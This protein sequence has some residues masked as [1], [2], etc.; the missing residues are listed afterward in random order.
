MRR[1]LSVLL[2]LAGAACGEPSE[3]MPSGAL[4]LPDA[5]RC[6]PVRE[7]NPELVAL[8][9][10][11]LEQLNEARAQGRGCGPRG[12]FAEAP[13]LRL[14]GALTCAAR[15]HAF[16]MAQREFFDHID[17]DDVTAWDRI[18]AVDY[19]FATAD[20]VIASA[21]LA[22]EDI[23]SDIW[24][25]REGSCAALSASSYVDV[26]IGVALPFTEPVPDNDGLDGRLW[27]LIVAKPIQ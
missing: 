12:S 23:L 1:G 24:L 5:Q 7:W 26:G 22:P 3:G 6:D 16:D 11:M 27:T 4:R 18:R 17:P 13:A 19:D 15:L 14:D 2:A 10:T 9:Q 8:E 25:P 21:D 20:E